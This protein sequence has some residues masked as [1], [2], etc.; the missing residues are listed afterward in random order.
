MYL[1]QHS[2][3]NMLD[4]AWIVHK[5]C[6]H[7]SYRKTFTSSKHTMRTQ[8]WEGVTEP[9]FKDERWTHDILYECF[10]IYS[11]VKLKVPQDCMFIVKEF[12]KHGLSTTTATLHKQTETLTSLQLFYYATIQKKWQTVHKA[13]IL[14]GR[15]Y[16]PSQLCDA[17]KKNQLLISQK[18]VYYG[19]IIKIWQNN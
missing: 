5:N 17:I 2:S 14:V 6:S 1:N 19:C 16:N 13:F 8:N 12:S 10:C 4:D 15:T 18:A 9:L 11:H 7:H 3:R